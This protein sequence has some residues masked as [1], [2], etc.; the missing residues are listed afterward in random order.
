[1]TGLIHAGAG[2]RAVTLIVG[3]QPVDMW[4]RVNINRQL[5]DLSGS[6]ELEMRDPPRHLATFP[7]TTPGAG[8]PVKFGEPC[9]VAVDGEIILKGWIED[10]HPYVEEGRAYLSVG[11]RDVTCDPVDCPPD[12]RGKHEYRN[13][14][15]LEGAKRV[16]AKWPNIT[17]RAEV[18]VGKP[19]D[20]WTVDAGET[21]LSSIE[22]HARKRAILVTSDGVGGVVL[23]RSGKTRAPGSLVLPGNVLSLGGNFSARERFSDYFVKG[24]SE[25][26]GGRKGDPALDAEAAPLGQSKEAEGDQSGE[27]HAEAAGSLVM[28]HAKD[29][30]V[31]RWRPFVNLSR[32]NTS[33]GDAQTYA[34]WLMRTRRGKSEQ[35]DYEVMGW[36]GAS[37]GLWRLNQLV[38]IDD[39]FSMMTRD[40]LIHGISY[41]YSA[42]GERTRIRVCGPEAYDRL[43][44]GERRNNKGGGRSGGGG[45]G[46]GL[47]STANP[48]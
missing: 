19:F 45:K 15:L 43:P 21:A 9:E 30:E 26:S 29:P 16:L 4:T 42:R 24:G 47:D 22:K 20:K 8:G 7:W 46:G 17:V 44:E 18:D 41:Q 35:A 39:S 5:T 10:V 25:K 27:G 13:V 14:T 2:T 23:T 34:D 40:Q 12:P 1:M 36:R 32:T 37:G 33:Q 3:G 11:G 6:F 28:G 48:L 31:T 38:F